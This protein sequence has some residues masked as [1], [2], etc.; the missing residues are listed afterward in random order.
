MPWKCLKYCIPQCIGLNLT[1]H[2]QRDETTRSNIQFLNNYL[3]WKVYC[4]IIIRTLWFTYS[5]KYMAVYSVHCTV[6]SILP[7]WTQ[8]VSSIPE[9]SGCEVWIWGS[10][11]SEWTLNEAYGGPRMCVCN[12]SE[13]THTHL[14]SCI[15]HLNI[16]KCDSL[17]VE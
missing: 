11:L 5:L 4:S 10:E 1:F 9:C 3:I 8:P 16:M 6:R 7:F 12:F 17:F 13:L 2:F 15:I 14:H